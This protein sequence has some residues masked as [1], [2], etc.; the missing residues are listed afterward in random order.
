MLAAIGVE[1]DRGAV[2]RHPGAL[3]L[4]EPLALDDGLSEQE[5]YEELRAL[6][7][8]NASTED[9]VSFL[10]AGMYDH[11]VPALIDSIIE[12]SEFLTPYTPYQPEV[13]QGG[14]QAMFEYQTAISE[15]TGLPDLQRLGV[16]GPERGGRRRLRGQARQSAAAASWSRAGCTP[17]RAR[18]CARC[19]RLGH[20]GR[21]GA[22][23]RRPHR[24]ARSSTT[25]SAR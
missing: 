5:V 20:G 24:A 16:R 18:R 10:G 4:G 11:Y 19:P 15:L 14:L 9:E 13:S 22:A 2:R 25:T 12:R 1:L 21:G 6:A 17:T 8:R 23:A 7:A 3:R